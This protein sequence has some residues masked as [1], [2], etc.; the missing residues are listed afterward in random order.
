[1]SVPRAAPPELNYGSQ[2]PLALPASTTKRKFF[3]TNG[4]TFTPTNNNIISIDI[5]SDNFLDASHSYFTCRVNNAAGGTDDAGRTLILPGPASFIKRLRVLSGGVELESIDQYSRL[6]NLLDQCQMD[7][8]RTSG[9]VM[10]NQSQSY[11][12]TMRPQP[13]KQ[14]DGSTNQGLSLIHI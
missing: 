11:M 13:L 10:H 7:H 2:V 3:P 5:N 9:S 14:Q 8:S 4:A 1:M 12:A 6:Y